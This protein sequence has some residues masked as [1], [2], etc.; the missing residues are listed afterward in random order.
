MDFVS[1]VVPTYNRKEAL[2]QCINSLLMQEYPKDKY[3]VI[4]VDDGS[5]DGTEKEVEQIA[6]ENSIL[7]Y[8]KQQNQ[9]PGAARNRGIKKAKGKII[10]FIDDDCIAEKNWIKEHLKGYTDEK[11]GG[12]GG[13]IQIPKTDS[14]IEKYGNTLL[15]YKKLVGKDGLI[16]TGPIT[17][18]ASYRKKALI[19][20]NG[21][22][23]KLRQYEDGDLGIKIAGKG[24][25]FKYL[26]NA[27]I[28]H[29]HR[30]GLKELIRQHY[31]Y[32]IGGA[33]LG[34]KHAETHSPQKEIALGMLKIGMLAVI[35]PIRLLKTP[36]EEDK[37]LAFVTP[38][39][40]VV[41]DGSRVLGKTITYLKIKTGLERMP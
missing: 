40:D 13:G 25:T 5:K 7:K 27:K 3:E 39:L 36:F 34:I 11:I 12:V 35:I 18:N 20:V 17:C 2:I 19:A 10:L 24:Y 8:H 26:P 31:N 9:G 6:E 30:M 22:D 1:V 16:R 32:G 23:E 4:V 33:L 41:T 28:T 14:I 29:K 37:K 38:F 15:N 21:F